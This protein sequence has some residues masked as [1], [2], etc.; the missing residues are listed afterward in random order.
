MATSGTVQVRRAPW[1]PEAAE[2]K[3]WQKK[4][5]LNEKKFTFCA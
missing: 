2:T 1:L 5:I 4:N 3:V